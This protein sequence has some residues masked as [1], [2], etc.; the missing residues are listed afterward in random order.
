M[1][2]GVTA[3]AVD[4]VDFQ[5]LQEGALVGTKNILQVLTHGADTHQVVYSYEYK[6][7]IMQCVCVRASACKRYV[8][9]ISNAIMTVHLLK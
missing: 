7:K 8:N 5:F 6:S 4:E 1:V 3:A 2:A 9:S